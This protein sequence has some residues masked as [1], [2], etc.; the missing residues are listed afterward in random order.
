[1]REREVIILQ[2]SSTYNDDGEEGNMGFKEGEM[3]RESLS[4]CGV[5]NSFP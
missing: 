3:G 1:M 5:P 2:C 4:S